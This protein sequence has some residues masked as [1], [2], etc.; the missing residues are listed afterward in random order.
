MLSEEF[1]AMAITYTENM[2]KFGRVVF[3]ICEWTDKQTYTDG[4]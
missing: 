2:V 4:H 3:E 1:G